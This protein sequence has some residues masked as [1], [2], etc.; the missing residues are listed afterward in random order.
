MHANGGVIVNKK[1]LFVPG[2]RK[3][4][5]PRS[6]ERHGK[7]TSFQLTGSNRVFA[8][9]F[10]PISD[11]VYMYNQ[12]IRTKHFTVKSSNLSQRKRQ[13]SATRPLRVN[14]EERKRKLEDFKYL[15]NKYNVD[16]REINRNIDLMS[17]QIKQIREIFA[18]VQREVPENINDNDSIN[19][20]YHTRPSVQAKRASF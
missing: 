5:M 10:V 12:A 13:V 6:R 1:H 19:I 20:R 11:G 14:F 9:C 3:I 8:L 17:Y 2:T 18:S 16:T 7:Q 4:A 15:D